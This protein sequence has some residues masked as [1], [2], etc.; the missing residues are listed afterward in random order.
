[1]KGAALGLGAALAVIVGLAALVEHAAAQRTA[2]LVPPG[3]RNAHPLDRLIASFDLDGDG[4]LTQAEINATRADTL[5]RF[6]TDADGVLSPLEFEALWLE[7][8]RPRLHARF[9][10]LDTHG[11][12]GVSSAEFEART[13]RLITHLDRSGDGFFSRQD[14]ARGLRIE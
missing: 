11:D 5:A 7:R 4:A 8:L 1:M 2:E 6:D 9:H 10:A 13:A 3:V 12:G 14:I